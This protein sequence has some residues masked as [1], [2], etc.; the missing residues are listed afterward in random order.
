MSDEKNVTAQEEDNFYSK[1]KYYWRQ[2]EA[3]CSGMLGGFTN[4]NTVD[5][6]ESKELLKKILGQFD[7]ANQPLRVLDCGAGKFRVV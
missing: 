5:A 4:V 1:G 2:V 7:S 6:A 3:S